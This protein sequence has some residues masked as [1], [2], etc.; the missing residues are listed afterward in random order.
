[1]Q[2]AFLKTLKTKERTMKRM[3]THR[4]ATWIVLALA[5]SAFGACGDS[6]DNSDLDLGVSGDKII[7]DL[8]ADE[9]ATVCQAFDGAIGKVLTKENLCKMIG[10]MTG[11]TA[12]T[13]GSAACEAYVEA[14]KKSSTTPSLGEHEI[15]CVLSATKIT[16]CSAKVSELKD[17]AQEIL[18]QLSSL[19]GDLSCSDLTKELD[20]DGIAKGTACTAL[21]KKCPKLMD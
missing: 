1:M 9:Q 3:N 16:G 15:K 2:M 6:D 19:V 20:F 21:K 17:C 10:V 7:S 18:T 4:W 12:S 13:G 14:C 11:K 8:T 5:L